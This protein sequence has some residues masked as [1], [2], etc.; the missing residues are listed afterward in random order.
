[1]KQ[2]QKSW[3]PNFSSPISKNDPQPQWISGPSFSLLPRKA[4]LQEETVD[5]DDSEHQIDNIA[6]NDISNWVKI[7]KSG[8]VEA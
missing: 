4:E 1:L 5:S 3:A 7:N 6:C 2:R 8:E